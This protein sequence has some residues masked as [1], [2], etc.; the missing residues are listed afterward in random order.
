MKA[1]T[2]LGELYA[3]GLGVARDDK[4]AA[5]WYRLAADRGDRE[6][7]FALAMFHLGGRAG[8]RQRRA[9]RQAARR[10]R[11]ARP[12][13]G[14]LRSRAC[15]ISKASLF[16]Q[17][18]AR[19]A[20]LFRS[21]AQAGS[22]GSAIRARHALQGGP[23]RAEGSGARRRGSLAAAALA[24]N[25][26]AAG[27]IRDRAVQRHRRRQGRA[28]GGRAVAARPPARATRSR[29]TGSPTFSRSG[30]ALHADPVEAIKWHII[31]KAGGVERP[32]RS[33]TS[34]QKQTPRGPR[35]RPRRR[36]SPG[37][38]RSRPRA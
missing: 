9:G 15:S 6:A 11:Q 22:P 29:R 33:T 17:D 18:F 12:R 4:K 30:A 14:G 21:A 28:R 32:L 36:R 19:A 16:P 24:D 31:A 38:M 26:D 8:P 20:E 27:R 2:L 5:E 13:A 37:S 34:T 1:M 3:N 35:R 7:M 25:T 10:R 23:R